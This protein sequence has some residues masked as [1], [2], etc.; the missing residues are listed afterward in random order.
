MAQ[1][2]HN[3]VLSGKICQ[4]VCR[5]TNREG[6]GCLLPDDQCTK[7]RRLVAEVLWEKHPYMRAPS[8]ENPTLQVRD[9]KSVV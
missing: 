3:T 9:R 7:T 8:V 2:C 6:R 4:A 5:A 1:S